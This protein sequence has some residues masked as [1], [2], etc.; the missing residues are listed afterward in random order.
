[1]PANVRKSPAARSDLLDHFVWIG[2]SSVA[3]ARRFL[4]A[5]DEAMERLAEM[6]EM[7]GEWESG[8]PGLA[9]LRV[10]P[11]R[12]FPR[13]LIFYKPLADGIEVVRVLHGSQDLESLLGGEE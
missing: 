5:A 7:G 2:R 11:I 1:M 12:R 13:Y 3:N 8:T 6:P 4:R 9:G 10:W